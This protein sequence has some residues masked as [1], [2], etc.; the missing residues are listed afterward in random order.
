MKK[1]T[2]KWCDFHKSPWNNTVD[3]HSKKSMVAEVK[4]Y[5]TDAGFESESK[6]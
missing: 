5:E 1:D 4:S 2:E 6:P 3:F